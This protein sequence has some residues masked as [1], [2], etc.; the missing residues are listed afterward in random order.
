MNN[1]I[2]SPSHSCESHSW[3]FWCGRNVR[4]L[5][6]VL[7]SSYSYVKS[8][9]NS[10][11]CW[12][13]RGHEFL[14]DKRNCCLW[15]AGTVG[16]EVCEELQWSAFSLAGAFLI[17]YTIMAL[18]GGIPLFYMELALGQYHR[19]GCISIWRKICPIFKGNKGKLIFLSNWKIF[20]W[21][22]DFRGRK[23]NL[24]KLSKICSTQDFGF[25]KKAFL[26]LQVH[27]HTCVNS[28]THV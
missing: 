15:R 11:V 23:E 8:H 18:F 21:M 7:L 2:C 10:V 20:Q 14:W 1:F 26:K 9:G 12:L 5:A 22:W 16:R 3:W 4:S 13:G 19:N 25:T 28:C 27:L 24:I 6:W 17:P